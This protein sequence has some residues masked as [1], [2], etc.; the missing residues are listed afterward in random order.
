VSFDYQWDGTED[1]VS[2]FLVDYVGEVLGPR[3]LDGRSYI[4][5]RS[6]AEMVKPSNLRT[7]GPELSA[8][9]VGVWMTPDPVE[10]V[11]E[12]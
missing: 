9:I 4:A 6:V 3:V 12:G 10:T 1:A 8:A 7:T 2:A 11:A 5:V